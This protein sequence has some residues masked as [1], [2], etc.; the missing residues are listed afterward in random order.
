[1][2]AGAGLEPT[3]AYHPSDQPGDP[4]N[5][6]RLILS[7]FWE[8]SREPELLT[9]GNPPESHAGLEPAKTVLQTAPLPLWQWLK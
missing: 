3:C 8:F 1:M 5:G 9:L 4:A 2:E 7:H 6:G